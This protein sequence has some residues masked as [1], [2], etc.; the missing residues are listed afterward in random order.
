MLAI[1]G[2]PPNIPGLFSGNEDPAWGQQ[3]RKNMDIE[4]I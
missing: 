3:T 1:L 2:A 4:L